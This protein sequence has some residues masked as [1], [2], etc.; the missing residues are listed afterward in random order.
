MFFQIAVTRQE[1]NVAAKYWEQQRKIAES[2]R[3]AYDKVNEDDYHEKFY[4]RFMIL[5]ERPDFF[6]PMPKNCRKK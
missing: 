6:E 3:D 5:S 1:K 2:I 4:K